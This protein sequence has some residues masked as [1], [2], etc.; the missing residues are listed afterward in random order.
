MV[1]QSTRTS[2]SGVRGFALGLKKLVEGRREEGSAAYRGTGR[3][4]LYK[5]EDGWMANE[6]EA[7]V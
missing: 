7:M 3:G 5:C 2:P 6:L 1:V 4:L